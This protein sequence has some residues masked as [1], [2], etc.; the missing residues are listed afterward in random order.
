MRIT[1]CP[2]CGEYH[3]NPARYRQSRDSLLIVLAAAI[4]GMILIGV[5]GGW[6]LWSMK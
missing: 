5:I 2:L 1:S 3:Q 4:G 6:A